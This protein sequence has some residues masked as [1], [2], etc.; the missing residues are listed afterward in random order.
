MIQTYNEQRFIGDCLDHLAEHGISA[1]LVD[2]ESSDDTVAIAERR[3]SA[4][5]IGIET[6]E[7]SGHFALQTQLERKEQLAQTLDADWL[8]H[9]DADEFRVSPD[10]GRSLSQAIEEIDEAGFNAVNFLE[11]TFVPTREQPDHDHPDFLRTMRSYYPVLPRFPHR[12]NAWKRQDGPVE[13][14]HSGG[15]IVNFPG[16]N[17]APRSLYARHYLFLS[18]SYA[19]RKFGPQ[20]YAPDELTRGMHRWRSRLTPATIELPS[21]RDLRT[22]VADHLLDPSSPF[23]HTADVVG[24]SAKYPTA[25]R[26]SL[27]RRSA[28]LLKRAARR[29]GLQP[30][31]RSGS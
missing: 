15:H 3:L 22:Y 1:Y 12:L 13:L 6:L 10:R 20:R 11:F 23:T 19:S 29:T 26:K 18:V 2:N 8:I 9:L 7:R 4:N 31:A 30:Q 16:L 25:K 28:R 27:R 24:Q 21:E 5:L 14:T 17:M